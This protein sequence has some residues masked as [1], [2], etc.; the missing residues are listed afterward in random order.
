LAGL[1]ESSGLPSNLT[2]FDTFLPGL[3]LDW[4][5]VRQKISYFQ[6]LRLLIRIHIKDLG[7][8]GH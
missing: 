1:V 8:F 3:Y 2:D 5:A 4:M 6:L 7:V